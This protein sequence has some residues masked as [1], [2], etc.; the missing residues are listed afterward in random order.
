MPTLILIFCIF[1]L[2]KLGPIFSLHDRTFKSITIGKDKMREGLYR[3][4]YGLP[5]SAE[6]ALTNFLLSIDRV[7]TNTTSLLVTLS[8]S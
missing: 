7:I 1:Q 6:S 8:V 2:D 5:L 3:L 4:L